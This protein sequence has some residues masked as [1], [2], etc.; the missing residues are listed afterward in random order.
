MKRAIPAEL[1]NGLYFLPSRFI[2]GHAF[3]S[4]CGTQ[5]GHHGKPEPVANFI[6]MSRHSH[7]EVPAYINTP[8]KP[9]N[10]RDHFIIQDKDHDNDI[11]LSWADEDT[12]QR[13]GLVVNPYQSKP[14]VPTRDLRELNF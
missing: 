7:G 10:D 14:V 1:T 12:I 6:G 3:C 9:L 11:L 5:D 2:G 8:L 13:L 4:C